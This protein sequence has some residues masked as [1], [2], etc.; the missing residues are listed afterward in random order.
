[1]KFKIVVMLFWFFILFS[2]SFASDYEYEV[3]GTGD[4]GYVHGE[5]EANKGEKEVE[6]YLYNEEGDQV[7][8]E[9][10]WTGKGEIEGYDENGDYIELEIE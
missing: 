4:S 9:G 1:M 5:I 7:H 3:S 2:N 6:G 10:E 8:F